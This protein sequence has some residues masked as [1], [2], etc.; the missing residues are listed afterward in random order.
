M[1]LFFACLDEKRKF[2]R[3]FE[4]ILKFFDDFMEK[5]NFFENLLLKIEP[6]EITPFST[7]IF[8]DRGGGI[9]PLPTPGYALGIDG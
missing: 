6:S 4:K 9:S 3:S 1:R 5:W 8:S 7:T 2:L